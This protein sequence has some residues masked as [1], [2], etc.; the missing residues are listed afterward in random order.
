MSEEGKKI[1][2]KIEQI[3]ILQ[4]ERNYKK[5]VT[6]MIELHILAV[7]T[8]NYSMISHNILLIE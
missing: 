5:L 6:V 1:H 7:A 3:T 4:S 2:E 8:K